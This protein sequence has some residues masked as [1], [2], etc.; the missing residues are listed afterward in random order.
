MINWE[1]WFFSVYLYAGI[2]ALQ[3]H[4]MLGEIKSLRGIGTEA[5]EG[6]RAYAE[7]FRETPFSSVAYALSG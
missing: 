5:Y 4:T 3:S 1:F 7:V 6:L 2:K